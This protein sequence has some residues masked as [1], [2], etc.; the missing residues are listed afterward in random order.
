MSSEDRTAK[1]NP[2]GNE[3]RPPAE[4]REEIEETRRELGE[5][6]AAVAEKTDVK[7]QAQAK[8]EDVKAEA[9]AKAE[10]G[11]QRAQSLARES[12]RPLA[13]AGAAVAVLLLWRL[14]RR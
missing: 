13:I 2:T 14:A 7:Q 12:P 3:E 9:S 5:T 10:A 6:V 8:V 1:E 4:I 11:L